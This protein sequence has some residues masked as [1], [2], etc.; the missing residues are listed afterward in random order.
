MRDIYKIFIGIVV[1]VLV[2]LGAYTSPK[3]QKDSAY[4]E[5]SVPFTAVS[6]ENTTTILPVVET[7]TTIPE[8]TTTEPTIVVRTTV[9]TRA[10]TYTTTTLS[11]YV[12]TTIPESRSSGSDGPPRNTTTLVGCIAYYESTW[13]D[14]SSN[15]FQFV[16]GTWN[17]YGG[18]GSPGNAP[19]WR[20]EEVFWAAW[21]DDGHHHWAAQKG[22]CF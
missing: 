8:T 5:S 18:T 7:T 22:R 11:S 6:I 1:C 13:G 12:S 2:V 15:V 14:S 20:Q 9:T 17:A 3:S 4:K 21:E 16:Q 10:A 19:Y